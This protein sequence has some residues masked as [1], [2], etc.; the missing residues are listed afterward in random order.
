MARKP[1][2]RRM[3]QG[4]GGPGVGPGLTSPTSAGGRS[5]A[6]PSFSGRALQGIYDDGVHLVVSERYVLGV[7]VIPGGLYIVKKLHA[8]VGG[9]IGTGL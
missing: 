3:V 6:A 1:A 5:V 7:N 9:R 4:A 2:L 8:L